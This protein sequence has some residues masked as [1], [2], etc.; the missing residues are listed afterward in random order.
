LLDDLA[1]FSLNDVDV[2]NAQANLAAA[3]APPES[4]AQRIFNDAKTVAYVGAFVACAVISDGACEV[5]AAVAGGISVTS[6]ALD[7][8]SVGS[9]ITDAILGYMS[10]QLAEITGFASDALE[11]G[12]IISGAEKYYQVRN[13]AVGAGGTAASAALC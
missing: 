10:A 6:D 5:G 2:G 1:P 12:E 7:H 13:L 3:F 8:C 4:T 11:G 9:T